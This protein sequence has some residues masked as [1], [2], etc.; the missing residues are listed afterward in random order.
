MSGAGRHPVYCGRAGVP[1]LDARRTTT[2]NPAAP[3]TP[4]ERPRRMVPVP[5]TEPTTRT[6]GAPGP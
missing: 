2:A 6:P 1:S 3:A 4:E 5:W